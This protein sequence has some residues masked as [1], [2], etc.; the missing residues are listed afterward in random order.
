MVQ[1]KA[2]KGPSLVKV[3]DTNAHFLTFLKEEKENKV[4]YIIFFAGKKEAQIYFCKK[5]SSLLFPF[6]LYMCEG[7]E[8]KDMDIER[9]RSNTRKKE[10]PYCCIYKHIQFMLFTRNCLELEQNSY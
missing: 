2:K 4:L 5:A 3:L 1:Y 10:A 6:C 9:G 7:S 8:K